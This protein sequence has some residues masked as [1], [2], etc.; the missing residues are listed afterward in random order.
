MPCQIAFITYN[1]TVHFHC[2]QVRSCFEMTR[3][4]LAQPSLSRPQ[5]LIMSD[6][7]DVSPPLPPEQLLVTLIDAKEMIK[8]LLASLPEAFAQTTSS[9]SCLGAALTAA[10]HM[11]PT[12]GRITVFQACLPN[13]GPGSIARA[14]DATLK[15]VDLGHFALLIGLQGHA[16]GADAAGNVN[17]LLQVVLGEH[18]DTSTGPDRAQIEAS[19]QQIA[20]DLFLFG[21][22]YLDVSTLAH[23][24]KYS[25]GT[26]YYFADYSALSSQGCFKARQ[27]IVR[28]HDLG[29]TR[30]ASRQA[31]QPRAAPQPGAGGRAAHPLHSGP[32]TQHVP[33]QLLRA[34]DRPARAAKHQPKRRLCIPIRGPF[35]FR[36]EYIDTTMNV[37]LITRRL[38]S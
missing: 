13:C 3:L 35:S 21:T 17:R 38:R 11:M 27:V 26:A 6:I 12:G 15:C 36:C 8:M 16:Q 32:V 34:L 4:R 1:S 9:S 28:S 5:T 18:A 19:R 30:R 22:D 2:L 14:E 24:S 31:N 33:R 25:G 10:R 7:D 23:A 20:I 37:T 29:S